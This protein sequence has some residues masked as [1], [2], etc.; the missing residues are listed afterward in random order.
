MHSSQMLIGVQ[1]FPHT[2]PTS[3]QDLTWGRA[4]LDISLAW[5]RAPSGA[6]SAQCSDIRLHTPDSAQ[7][8]HAA[9]PCQALPA[10]RHLASWQAGLLRDTLPTERRKLKCC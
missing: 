7:L 4:T 3:M 8:A 9:S 2:Q 1:A 10:P 6:F 5:P